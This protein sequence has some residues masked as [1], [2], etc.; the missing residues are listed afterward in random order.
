[1]AENEDRFEISC[2]VTKTV[3]RI[4]YG[5]GIVCTKNGKPYIDRQDD[6]IS[7]ANMQ[8]V[9]TKFM[10]K[11]RALKAMHEGG[12]IGEVVHSMPMTEELCKAYGYT[13]NTQNEQWLV[14]VYVEDDAVLA[15]AV[16]GELPSFSI[17]GKG[18]RQKVVA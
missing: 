18:R 12:V 15:K 4:I 2:E 8:E 14:G 6:H 11:S 16:K 1:M 9:A 3:G 7:P 17:G 13:H 10:R 5:V